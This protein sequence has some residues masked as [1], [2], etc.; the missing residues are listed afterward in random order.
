[1]NAG[2]PSSLSP[3][4]PPKKNPNWVIIDAIVAKKLASVMIITSRFFTCV[5]S[6]AITASSSWGC[7]AFMMPVVVHTTADF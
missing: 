4:Q 7:N 6:C 5:S 2:A 3:P 1:M